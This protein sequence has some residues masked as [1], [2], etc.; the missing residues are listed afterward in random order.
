MKLHWTRKLAF[1]IGI[2]ESAEKHG[3]F[4]LIDAIAS[5]QICPH[6]TAEG[7]QV[8][9]LAVTGN[10]AILTMTDGNS[11]TAIVTQQIKFTDFPV[12]GTEW[13]CVE[14]EVRTLML[15]DEY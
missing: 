15:P 8:W 7:F 1:T 2:E 14:G 4:W 12:P 3:A 6:V 11:D 9:K 13:W 10:A 5:H